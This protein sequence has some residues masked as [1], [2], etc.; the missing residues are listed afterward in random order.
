[1]KTNDFFYSGH[2]GIPIIFGLEFYRQNMK[3]LLAPCLFVS[4]FEGSMMLIMR[5][6]YSI[7]LIFGVIFAHY[8][9]KI[10]VYIEPIFSKFVHYLLQ[11][12]IQN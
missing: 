6:H 3:Y 11:N 10:A 9:H 4:V 8:F 5:G 1:M 2:I 12:C 7:D